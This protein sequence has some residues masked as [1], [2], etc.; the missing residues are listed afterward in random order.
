MKTRRPN[1]TKLKRRKES[2]PA[3]GRGSS[4]A[5]LQEQLEGRTREL[6]EAREQ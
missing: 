5:D 2:T 6:V 3:R 1:T 4:P